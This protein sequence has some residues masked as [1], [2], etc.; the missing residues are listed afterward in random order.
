MKNNYNDSDFN[1]TN[2]R[3]KFHNKPI[4]ENN[5]QHP[6]RELFGMNWLTRMIQIFQRYIY[7]GRII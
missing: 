4:H 6:E 3:D 7:K 2:A 1:A 5:F